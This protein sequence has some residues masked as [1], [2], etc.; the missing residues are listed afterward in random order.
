MYEMSRIKYV[1][2]HHTGINTHLLSE[3]KHFGSL[4]NEIRSRY[5]YTFPLAYHYVV[6]FNGTIFTGQKE[7]LVSPHC[8][9]DKGEGEITNWNALGISCMGNFDNEE[10][11]QIQFK[12]LIALLRNIQKK[13]PTPLAANLSLTR[14]FVKHKSIVRTN[15][16][17]KY[18]PYL[19]VLQELNTS[20]NSLKV[21]DNNKKE[22]FQD[23]RVSKN[24]FD[25]PVKFCLDNGIMTGDE[26]GFRPYDPVS[27]VELASVLFRLLRGDKK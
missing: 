8:G 4:K 10:M 2:L 15:C 1:V 12:A 21:G 16:P 26:D 24:W 23:K 19:G 17:G 27:R 20:K 13:Y 14:C 18:F 9:L 11:K 3:N 5:G 6:G 7:G 25:D 22:G